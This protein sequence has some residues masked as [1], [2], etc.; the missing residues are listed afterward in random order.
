ML[1]INSITIRLV[2]I[3]GMTV[4]TDDDTSVR[5]VLNNNYNRTP[6]IIIIYNFF[7]QKFLHN[8][9][10]EQTKQTDEIDTSTASLLIATR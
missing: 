9:N 3:I 8:T 10:W 7:L 6:S 1:L 5:G 4:I 2:I